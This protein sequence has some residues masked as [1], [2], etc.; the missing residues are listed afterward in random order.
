MVYTGDKAAIPQLI[1]AFT[2]RTL[3]YLGDHIA[4]EELKKVATQD[5]NPKVRSRAKEAYYR[6]SGK[7]LWGE[8]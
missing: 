3:G 7:K 1:Q 5:Q 2:A 6:I 4:L 8:D